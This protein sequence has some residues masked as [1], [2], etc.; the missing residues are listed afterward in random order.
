M[1]GK[2]SKKE[3]S[4]MRATKNRT[5]TGSSL[6]SRGEGRHIARCVSGLMVRVELFNGNFDSWEP[7]WG[8]QW[9]FGRLKARG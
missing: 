6:A 4:Y 8:W 3:I 7:K 9:D 1:E 2:I 5:R